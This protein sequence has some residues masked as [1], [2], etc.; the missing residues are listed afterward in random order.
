MKV[1][2]FISYVHIVRHF[3]FSILIILFLTS[4]RQKQG[5]NTLMHPSWQ[6]NFYKYRNINASNISSDRFFRLN[7]SDKDTTI[8]NLLDFPKTEIININSCSVKHIPSD[9]TKL[10][11]LKALNITWTDFNKFPR[12]LFELP[13]L[14]SL[15]IAFRDTTIVVDTLCYNFQRLKNIEL[16]SL[17]SCGLTN[18]PLPLTQ[19]RQL[20]YLGLG[21]NKIREITSP[22]GNLDSLIEVDFS[23]NKL[24]DL[25]KDFYKLKNLEVADFSNNDISILPSNIVE[26]N[27]VREINLMNNPNF[28]LSPD[29]AKQIKKNWKNLKTILLVGTNHTESDIKELNEILPGKLVFFVED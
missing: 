16:L 10:K 23:Q 20:K 6:D 18:L 2:I 3:N 5:D 19:M 9:I 12:I 4:C 8:R 15:D 21:V 29:L 26:L 22:I 7:S 17:I 14:I 1:R 13:N 25:P 27:L 28:K 11:E 24:T